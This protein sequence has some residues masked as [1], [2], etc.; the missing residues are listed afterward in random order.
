MI[1]YLHRLCLVSLMLS[2][3]TLL[4]SQNVNDLY[5]HYDSKKGAEIPKVG[6]DGRKYIISISNDEEFKEINSSIL[7]ALE[8]GEKNIVIRLRQ[9]EYHFRNNHIDLRGLFYPETSI[10]I[11][12]NGSTILPV[13]KE[14]TISEQHEGKNSCL[15]EGVFSPESLFFTDQGN[16]LDVWTAMQQSSGTVN[17]K[18]KKSATIGT[19]FNGIVSKDSK[20]RIPHWYYSA[21]YPI[22]EI[23]KEGEVTFGSK[24][25]KG[26]DVDYRGRFVLD[27]DYS[28]AGEPIRYQCFNVQNN[29]VP[30]CIDKTLYFP[31]KYVSLYDC[32]SGCFILMASTSLRQ[33]S[34][35]DLKCMGARGG[36]HYIN[37]SSVR[38]DRIA[39]SK[40]YF[41]GLKSTVLM[42]NKTDNVSFYDNVIEHCF[43]QG[44]YSTSG[45]KNTVVYRCIFSNNG[46]N[47]IQHSCVYC[48][49]E[50]YHIFENRICDFTYAAIFVGL[51]FSI[52][53]NGPSCGIIENNEIFYTKEFFDD[54]WK[55]TLADGGAI[56]ISTDSDEVIIRNNYIH[57]YKGIN[58]NRAIF[59]DTGAKNVIIYGNVI[60]K[61]PNYY[62]IDLYRVKSADRNVHDANSG[63]FVFG[64]YIDGAYKIGGREDFSCIDGANIIVK[65]DYNRFNSPM[66]S[67]SRTVSENLSVTNLLTRKEKRIAKRHVPTYRKLQRFF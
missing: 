63:N 45:S 52:T 3:Y 19:T 7:A 38:A 29:E 60:K 30:Y 42:I 64:N 24:T 47:M 44:V 46:E 48:V 61:V 62:A 17:V 27:Y 9:G 25:D 20:I 2:L 10:S 56:Y 35:S 37:L 51:H 53:K 8:K 1:S 6:I 23:S 66:V 12:G 31:K 34:V 21:Q 4:S 67:N 28:V 33:F 43:A 59:G 15:F 65:N 58:G 49:G 36:G 32:L 11:E 57:S 54:Y 18:D 50:N 39:F 26:F 22:Y 13:W 41:M 5:R 14:Y 40:C 16:I 55:H